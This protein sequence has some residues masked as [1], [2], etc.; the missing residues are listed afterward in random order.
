MAAMLFARMGF[1]VLYF[2][3]DEPY[4]TCFLIFSI[5]LY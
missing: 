2:L 1:K 3:P 5:S 4:M